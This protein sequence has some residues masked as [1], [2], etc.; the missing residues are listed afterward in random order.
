MSEF[1]FNP[2]T[3]LEVTERPS[4]DG[5]ESKALT[6]PECDFCTDNR[7]RWQYDCGSFEVPERGIAST[8]GWAACDRCSELVERD[9][10]EALAARSMRSW[11]VRGLP[12]LPLVLTSIREMQGGFFE[13][14]VGGRRAFG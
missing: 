9:D 3:V 4:G 13:H 2:I 7:V 11:E 5:A 12:L 6:P 10:R 14:R 8:G 1:R